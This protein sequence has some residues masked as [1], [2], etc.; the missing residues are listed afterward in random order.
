M[1]FQ[2][3]DVS[4]VIIVDNSPTSYMLQP[5]N[6]VAISSWFDDPADTQLYTLLPW[7]VNVSH[8]ENVLPGLERLH[9]EMAANGGNFWGPQGEAQPGGVQVDQGDSVYLELMDSG[10]S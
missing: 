3:R 2:G 4:K 6:A 7:F 8:D 9:A 5:E 10:S 1:R